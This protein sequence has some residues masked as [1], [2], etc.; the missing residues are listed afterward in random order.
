M[1]GKF[2]SR[3]NRWDWSTSIPTTRFNQSITR[4]SISCFIAVPG[5]FEWILAQ[6]SAVVNDQV[7]VRA[8]GRAKCAGGDLMMK[9]PYIESEN[10][11][12]KEQKLQL[13]LE[14]GVTQTNRLRQMSSLSWLF[15]PCV[16]PVSM[17][18]AESSSVREH[19]LTSCIEFRWIVLR[20]SILILATTYKGNYGV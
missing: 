8:I 20:K 14:A 3:R 12:K 11:P 16:Y 13:F 1:N 15:C 19:W 2:S 6:A 4:L 10:R 7:P 9:R 18:K 5:R 17:T